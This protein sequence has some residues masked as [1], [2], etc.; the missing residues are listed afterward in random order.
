[1]QRKY[2][3]VIVILLTVIFCS[4]K[5]YL[6]DLS[7][8]PVVVQNE[9]K[10]QDTSLDDIYYEAAIKSPLIIKNLQ[11]DDNEITYK[12]S[13]KI[14]N[15]SG[16]YKGTINNQDTYI[17][18]S[19]NGESEFT[20]KSNETLIIYDVPNELEYTIEQLTNV[21]DKYTTKANDLESNTAT[22]TIYLETNIIFENNTKLPNEEPKDDSDDKPS[23]DIKNPD[24]DDKEE[25]KN[26]KPNSPEDN[27]NNQ[28]NKDN[29]VTSDKIPLIVIFAIAILLVIINLKG[30]KIKRFE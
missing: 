15:I 11:N 26:E 7:S 16:T 2:I 3:Y 14:N 8:T 6:V 12:Y 21:D 30:T 24:I 25:D 18:F 9:T 23:E 17:I 28:D 10:K 20:L 13:I 29:P 22:G 19:A 4:T 5:Y 27:N 1:M